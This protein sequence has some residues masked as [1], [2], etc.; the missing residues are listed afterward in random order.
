MFSSEITLA[1]AWIHLL[2]VD[3]FAARYIPDFFF[4]PGSEFIRTCFLKRVFCAFSAGKFIKM[5]YLIK[6]R[7]GILFRFAFSS[8]R[9]ES[10]HIL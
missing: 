3:L 8:A 10:F 2:V 5:G 1:S 7:R 4:S 6:S 9:L